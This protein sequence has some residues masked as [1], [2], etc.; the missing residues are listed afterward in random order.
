M[1][2]LKA[3][4]PLLHSANP[5]TLPQS[6]LTCIDNSGAALVEC[7]KVLKMKRAAKV[8]ACFPPSDPT[9]ALTRHTQ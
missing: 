9:H 3:P 5:L 7:V 4:L 1:I 6:M 8:G 2:Q